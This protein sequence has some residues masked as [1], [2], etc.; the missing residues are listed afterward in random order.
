MADEI[1]PVVILEESM[2]AGRQWKPITVLQLPFGPWRV[3]STFAYCGQDGM[4]IAIIRGPELLAV[5]TSGSGHTAWEYGSI[6][7]DI[8][9]DDTRAPIEVLATDAWKEDDE[10]A[11]APRVDILV[12][13]RSR[14]ARSAW[15]REVKIITQA[16]PFC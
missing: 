13:M 15:L 2:S 16:P 6:E 14:G 7:C 10:L 3:V 8:E 1:E 9:V 11:R 12:A 4:E 5:R